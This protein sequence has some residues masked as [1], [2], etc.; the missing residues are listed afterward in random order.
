MTSL[1]DFRRADSIAGFS[2]GLIVFWLA[3][4]L[5]ALAGGVF[6]LGVT[7][8]RLSSPPILDHGFRAALASASPASPQTGTLVFS[9]YLGGL[10]YEHIRDVTTDGEGNIYITGGTTSP[11][12]PVTAG[13]YQTKHNPGSPDS[14]RISPFDVFAVK[15]DPTGRIL[16]STFIGGPNYDRA[17]AIKVD[18]QGYVYVAGLAGRGFPVTPGAFQTTFMG[19]QE[20]AFYGPLDGFVAKLKPDGSGLVWASYFGTSDPA[21]IRD[22]AIDSKGDIYIASSYSSGTYPPAVQRAFNNSPHGGRDAVVAKI[23]SDGSQV[24]WATYIGGSGWESGENSIRLDGAD[25]P[26]VLLTTESTDIFTSPTAYQRSYAG[27]QDLYVAKLRPEDGQLVW[28]TYL[29]GSKNESTE[30]HEFAVDQQGNVYIAAPTKSTDF[31]TTPGAFQRTYGGGDNE[32]F[33][34]KI[35]AD[36]SRLLAST[37]VGGSGNDR[38]EG[39]AVDAMGNVYFTGTTTSANFPVTPDAFQATLG[40]T[41][42][43]IAV[44]LSADFSHLLYST[45]LGG[46]GEEFGRAATVDSQGNFCL[47]G[48]TNSSDWPTQN[49]VQPAY[50]GNGDAVVAKF[51]LVPRR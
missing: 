47:G 41:R 50:R 40:G 11:D 6:V 4:L 22:L 25:N 12:F 7:K 18:N 36:G 19:G 43:A 35:S 8:A 38:P 31:P 9:T 37:F 28:A 34:A 46:S 32:A 15:L 39:V 27:D 49:A 20:A 30:T 42:D 44:V 3:A 23:K 33:V 48:E 13:A 24:L 26:Y 10:Q 1:D 16:W 21:G 5:T 17:Y 14:S 45:Y 2:P 29:G 51:K